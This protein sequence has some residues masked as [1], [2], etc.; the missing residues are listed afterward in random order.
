METAPDSWPK[1]QQRFQ[2]L[3]FDTRG[4]NALQCSVLN[5]AGEHRECAGRAL[6]AHR[7]CRAC[8]GKLFSYLTL[9]ASCHKGNCTLLAYSADAEVLILPFELNSSYLSLRNM[10]TR[11]EYHSVPCR[12]RAVLSSKA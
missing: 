1:P 3:D 8:L 6:W 9:Q 7:H 10:R 2:V 11:V 4:F 5:D 12:S